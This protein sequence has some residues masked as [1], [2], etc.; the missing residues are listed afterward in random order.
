MKNNNIFKLLPI[1]AAVAISAQASAAITLYDQDATTFS[2]DGLFNTFYVNSD[3]SADGANDVSQSRVK[4]GFLPNYI[5][6]NF[7]KEIDGLTVGGRSS[8]WI[9]TSDTDLNRGA[10]DLGTET[11]IDARQVYAT[12]DGDFGQ[13]L[14]GK[15]FGLFNRSNIFGDEMLLGFGQT[16]TVTD[17]GGNVSFGNIGTGYLY[18]V[19]NSQITYRMPAMG[20]F[21][22]AVGLMD[23]NKRSAASE[24][25]R[26]RIEAEGSYALDFDGG[27]AKGWLG[28]MNQESKEAGT[29]LTSK[30]V[31]YGLNVKFAGVALTAS[32]FTAEGVGA[33]GLGNILTAD[34]AEVDGKLLQASYT[35]GATRLV[36][37]K[38][39][40]DG[41]STD[42]GAELDLKNKTLAVFHSVNSNLILVGEWDKAESA[43]A[44]TTTVALGAVVTF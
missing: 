34:S 35:L 9:S 38:G 16:M 17:D 20:G 1:A 23:P 43:T 18:P 31:S 41:G 19:P 8:L 7:S 5:G 37:S 10:E 27:S 6:F 3:S 28:Y 40:N 26:P 12:V 25:S 32:G 14:V 29:S 4:M 21:N 44:E 22:L 30:G 42:G 39:D 24:E 33:A 2:V 15:D 11:L 36:V 13:V